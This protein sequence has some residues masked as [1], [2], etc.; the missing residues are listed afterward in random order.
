M[1]E[2]SAASER[3]RI[4]RRPQRARYDK[5]AVFDVFD[6]ALF[7]HIGFVLDGQP[8]VTP[9]T[10]WRKGERLYWHGSRNSR[11]IETQAKGVDVCVNVA[12]LDALVLSRT[13][14]TH[15]ARYH[16]ATAY[17]R[18]VLIDDLDGKARAMNAFIDRVCPGRAAT[19]RPFDAN[20]LAQIC[21]IAMDIEDAAAKISEGGVIDREADLTFPVWAGVMKVRTH[22]DS[23]TTDI[24]GR[25]GPVPPPIAAYAAASDLHEALL[26]SARSG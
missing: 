25:E 16:S 13:G 10:F 12:R 17:G 11:T 15:S 19:L 4:M 5:E 22:V 14:F 8:F 2:S 18:T 24:Q 21:V 9:T 26:R 7:A 20:E 1:T 23:I 3:N 6:S